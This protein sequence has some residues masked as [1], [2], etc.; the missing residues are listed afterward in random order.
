M[1]EAFTKDL[2]FDSK[3][4]ADSHDSQP[5]IDWERRGLVFDIRRF[6]THDG[7]GIRTTVFTKGCPLRCLW[8]QNPEG[9][10][11]RRQLF[12]FRDKCIGCGTCIA[13]CPQQAISR[14]PGSEDRK[15]V[16]NRARCN[17]CGVCTDVCPP[18]ALQFDSR[19]MTVREVV[20]EVLLDRVFFRE[21][22][23]LT[24][25]GGD[26]TVQA[27][28]NVDIL[29]AVK[30]EG[31]HT[32]IE[33][34]L[35]TA[36]E[37]LARFL[38]HLDLLIADCKVFDPDDHRA[39]TGVDHSLILEN[40]RTVLSSVQGSRPELLVRIPLIP[41]HTATVANL[42]AIGRFFAE[43]SPGQRIELLNYNPLAQG[44][45]RLLDQPYLFAKN[46]R[47]FTAT[48]MDEFTALLTDL[49]LTAFHE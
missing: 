36:P 49:G 10:E 4:A 9:I 11:L 31:I 7:P 37:V 46:P 34:S 30:A 35:Y 44:K 40:F 45:Y 29:R 47:L 5:A 17:L 32:A 21:Q 27:A 28:F 20:D 39:W 1:L 16:I 3:A 38:P 42:T 25:T 24:I 41:D 15:I 6:S 12:Y 23:G 14:E 22:G 26:P 19:E 18:Q 43:L 13:S 2:A 48:E 33:T 8:C